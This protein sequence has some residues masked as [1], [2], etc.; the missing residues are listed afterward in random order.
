MGIGIS[1]WLLRP[2]RFGLFFVNKSISSKMP[3]QRDIRLFRVLKPEFVELR[4]YVLQPDDEDEESEHVLSGKEITIQV[5]RRVAEVLD[6]TGMVTNAKRLGDELLYRESQAPTAIGEG[7]AIPHVR[8]KNVRDLIMCFLRY[9]EGAAMESL[10]GKPVYFVFGF[11]TPI[12]DEDTDYQKVFRK[13]ISIF[14]TD[15]LFRM[16]L[17]EMKDPGEIVRI[18]RQR[19]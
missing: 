12:Y 7:I 8:S 3:Q 1:S 16:E 2:P 10:D 11:A 19:E 6:R 4:E 9:P 18:L 5:I 17:M 14:Q 13:L 15:E